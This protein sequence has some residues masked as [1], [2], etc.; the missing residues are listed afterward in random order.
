MAVQLERDQV[1][2]IRVALAAGMAPDAAALEYALPVTT[3]R[4]I[5]SGRVTGRVVPPAELAERWRAACMTRDEWT[6]WQDANRRLTNQRAQAP[7]PCSDCTLGFAADMRAVGRCNGSPAGTDHQQEENDVDP[8]P[9]P[10]AKIATRQVR[11]ALEAPCGGCNHSAVCRIA[12]E[13]QAV[14]EAKVDALELRGTVECS[15]YQPIRKAGRPRKE[16]AEGEAPANAHWTPERRAEQA[17]RLRQSN[18]ARKAAREAAGA[19]A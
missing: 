16:R 18:A 19:E 6:A 9:E 17:E 4:A 5:A 2:E 11:I 12:D 13:V 15:Y 1:E 8:M 14:A 10:T 3:I 7:R